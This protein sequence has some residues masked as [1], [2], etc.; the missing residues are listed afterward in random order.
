MTDISG[1]RYGQLT[2]LQIVDRRHHS[3]R[4]KVKCDCGEEF[5]VMLPHLKTDKV[6]CCTACHKLKKKAS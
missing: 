5:V 3:F 6:D 4:V 1:R 2:V